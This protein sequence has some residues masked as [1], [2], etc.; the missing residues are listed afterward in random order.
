MCVVIMN[1]KYAESRGCLRQRCTRDRI[2][3]HQTDRFRYCVSPIHYTRRARRNERRDD[4]L[5]LFHFTRR[6]MG[7]MEMRKSL[8][9][10]FPLFYF[11][12]NVCTSKSY[13]YLL[14]ITPTTF[15][16]TVQELWLGKKTFCLYSC[17]CFQMLPQG[18]CL[19]L[20]S[21]SLYFFIMNLT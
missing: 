11:C 16:T 8:Y 15:E 5:Q 1:Y 2:H 20:R 3:H 21:T 12:V 18:T 9:L 6:W 13:W 7:N 14:I 19:N 4:I 10:N 17:T